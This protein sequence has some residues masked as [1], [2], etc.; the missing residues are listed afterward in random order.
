[1]PLVCQTCGHSNNWDTAPMP[2]SS[3]MLAPDV[4]GQRA[5][6]AEIEAE[7]A[8][9][10]TYSARYIFALE[11]QKEEV[12]ARLKEIVYPILS[13]P[14]E[15]TSQI[16][17]ECLEGIRQRFHFLPDDGLSPLTA[18]APWLLMQVCRKW[19]EIALSTCQLWSFLQIKPL[20]TGSGEI[21][22]PAGT[23]FLLETWF[24]RA[25]ACP[26][27]LIIDSDYSDNGKAPEPLDISSIS[28]RLQHLTDVL[29]N[30]PLLAELHCCQQNIDFRSF[31]SKALTTLDIHIPFHPGISTAEFISI[32][33]SLPSLCHL[34]CL[35]KLT[36]DRRHHTPLT[37]PNLLSLCL[38]TDYCYSSTHVPPIHL[39]ELLT[40]PNL[41]SF[42]YFET[43]DPNVILPFLSRSTC[44]IRDLECV[45]RQ[46]IYPYENL[47]NLRLFPSVETLS[48]FADKLVDGLQPLDPFHSYLQLMMPN[49]QHIMITCTRNP[50]SP[51]YGCIIHVVHGRRVHPDTAELQSLHISGSWEFAPNFPPSCPIEAGVRSLIASGLD[52]K[53]F[54]PDRVVWPV[55]ATT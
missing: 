40:L 32:L 49:L 20:D 36:A 54:G 21:M 53:I 27:S 18:R 41:R 13:L 11:K 52:L 16:F 35:V 8:R 24:S 1:M 2:K 47:Q 4:F 10:K 9:F 34:A 45:A 12:E 39:L 28:H 17:V 31:A 42:K 55:T 48:I 22:V 44:A 51:D 37:F 46:T 15:I 5:A 25:G 23:L 19:K 26:L 3:T 7:I 14:A 6:L 50:W 43:L 29:K 33:Q 30:A 38:H